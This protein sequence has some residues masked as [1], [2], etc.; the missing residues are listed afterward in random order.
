[1]EREEQGQ[2]WINIGLGGKAGYDS[3]C[4]GRDGLQY[5]WMERECTANQRL[6]WCL[7]G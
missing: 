5:S 4:Y 6:F 2:A 3:S 1:M 7:Y